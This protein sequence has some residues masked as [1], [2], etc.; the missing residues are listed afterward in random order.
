M[1]RLRGNMG[2]FCGRITILILLAGF[3]VVAAAQASGALL[4]KSGGSAAA[5]AQTPTTV[6]QSGDKAAI[7]T[8]AKPA[9]NSQTTQR[10]AQILADTN[11]LLQLAQELKIEVSKSNKDIL[12]FA[13]VKKADAIEKLA[14]NLKERM[15]TE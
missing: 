10:Q 5:A 11:R 4:P 9:I 1:Q 13:V 8:G 2:G 3:P 14:K 15:R 12:S 7:Q 6:E